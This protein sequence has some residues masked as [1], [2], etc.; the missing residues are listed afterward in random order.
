MNVYAVLN[1][2]KDA[3]LEEIKKS[4]RR[5]ALR[6]HPDKNPQCEEQFRNVNQAYN[7]LSDPKKRR[8]Y[9]RY[10]MA[11][12]NMMD[13]MGPGA[14]L[15]DPEFSPLAMERCVYTFVDY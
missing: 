4:Y 12:V 15:L 7:I 13:T 6:Y 10:G 1:V 2:G 5:L 14:I 8:I 3:T 11:G 9:D